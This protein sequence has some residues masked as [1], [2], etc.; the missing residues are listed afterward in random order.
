[1]AAE[2]GAALTKTTEIRVALLPGLDE[3]TKLEAVVDAVAGTETL[4]RFALRPRM[5]AEGRQW[6]AAG[7][8]PTL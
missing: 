7:S 4:P 8:R 5:T 2:A 3:T 6:A 1:M